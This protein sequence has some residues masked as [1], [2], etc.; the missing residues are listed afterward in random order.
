MPVPVLKEWMRQLPGAFF[1]N[2]YG[3]TEATD[4]VTYYRVDRGFEDNET[5]PIGRPYPNTQILLLDENDR[6]VEHDGIGELCIKG[7]S[8]S[9]G[10]YGDK[11]KTD[12][13]FVQNPLNRNYREIIYRMGDLVKY[14]EH[15]ELIY[16]GRKDSQIQ[17]MGHRVEL[18]E[19]EAAANSSPDVTECAC[20]YNEEKKQIV[21]FYE[22]VCEEKA[23]GKYLKGALPEYM[24]PQRRYRL[25][26]MPKNLNGKL[27]RKKLKEIL[28]ECEANRR[29]SK[30]SEDK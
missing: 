3:S 18:G 13:A 20:I 16:V 17:H 29:K 10:Y 22:G 25:E 2:G 23:L 9:Y 19:I 15:G 11:E 12:Q 28:P 14:N 6:L 27:D 1:I 5:L 21:L 4:G 7:P 30:R 26:K 24:L 8:L